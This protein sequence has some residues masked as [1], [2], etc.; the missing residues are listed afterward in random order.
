MFTQLLSLENLLIA[1]LWATYGV[2]HSALAW[3]G[4][5]RRIEKQWPIQFGSYRL[6]YNLLALALLVPLL[7]LT[8]SVDDRWL[9]Q[10][11]GYGSWLQHATTLAVLIGFLISSRAYDMREFLGI[12]SAG[13]R[14]SRFG[15][16]PLHRCVRHPWYFLGLVWL[17]TRDMDTARL[18]AAAT[19]TVYIWAGAWLEDRKLEKE[20]GTSYREYRRRVPGLMPRPG[21]CLDR[22]TFLKLKNQA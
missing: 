5:K 6:A 3:P 2:L 9:W 11:T 18:T 1:L 12:R 20:L 22:D 4:I 16:S 14:Q 17:W 10:W 8:E 19:V 21:R 15:L 7:L 13:S